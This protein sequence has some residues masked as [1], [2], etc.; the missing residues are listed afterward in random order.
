MKEHARN[1][2][3]Q[4]LALSR[5]PYIFSRSCRLLSSGRERMRRCSEQRKPQPGR[6]RK[7]P[8]CC[9]AH[10]CRL[11]AW[12]LSRSSCLTLCNP[13]DCSPRGSSVHGILQAR[14]LEWVAMPPP[15]GLP[16]PG[17]EPASL[18]STASQA[19]SLLM[20]H[21]GSL[22]VDWGGR[23]AALHTWSPQMVLFLDLK[24]FRENLPSLVLWVEHLSLEEKI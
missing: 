20:S 3:A 18:S 9:G 5:A 15:G 1:C 12:A 7:S 4:D 6:G 23:K 8:G 14:I 21:R 24:N 22:R 13:V 19:D 17:I 2:P 10:A 16:N 11:R